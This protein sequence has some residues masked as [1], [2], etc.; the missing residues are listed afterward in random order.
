MSEDSGWGP[1]SYYWS[2]ALF[3]IL[4]WALA[5]GCFAFTDGCKEG[6]RAKADCMAACKNAK[7]PT[8]CV[9]YCK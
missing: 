3:W 8:S 9:R 7:D 4:F 5:F 6:G 1:A 2:N